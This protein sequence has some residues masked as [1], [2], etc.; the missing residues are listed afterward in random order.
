MIPRL[1]FKEGCFVFV[2]DD[3]FAKNQ[4]VKKQTEQSSI[5]IYLVVDMLS[6]T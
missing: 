1:I 6:I 2:F 5:Y 3:S 4:V